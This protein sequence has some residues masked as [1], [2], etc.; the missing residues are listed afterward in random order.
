VA[1]VTG[2]LFRGSDMDAA[3]QTAAGRH[4]RLAAESVLKEGRVG[5][6]YGALACGVDIIVA[7][8]ALDLG[9]ELHAVLPFSVPSFVE[10]SVEIGDPP[11]YAG[12]WKARFDAALSCAASLTIFEDRDPQGR[13][14]DGYFYHGFRFMAG[15]ALIRAAALGRECRLIAATDGKAPGNIAGSDR[16]V[17]DWRAAGR[18]VDLI[19]LPAAHPASGRQLN[20][21]S[22]FRACVYLWDGSGGR[23]ENRLAAEVAAASGSQAVRFAAASSAAGVSAVLGSIEAAIRLAE[24]ACASGLHAVCDFGAV[25]GADGRPDPTVIAGRAVVR[26]LPGLPPGRPLATLSFAAL[27]ATEFGDR[28]DIHEVGPEEV[29][30]AGCPRPAV[31]RLALK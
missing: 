4:V 1:V 30:G 17:E 9:I 20:V 21:D 28:L 25:L 3:A 13:G 5:L 15:L 12:A 14:L 22:G 10:L 31:Y 24:A 18:P 26:R 29:K 6:L 19:E 11:G 23:A 16:A 2:R 8:V 27:A 7:E